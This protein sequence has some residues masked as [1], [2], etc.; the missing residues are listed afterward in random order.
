MLKMLLTFSEIVPNCLSYIKNGWFSTQK[1]GQILQM[2][3]DKD[4]YNLPASND[5][6]SN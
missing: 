3:N 5:R 6:C 2:K 4:W 1:V